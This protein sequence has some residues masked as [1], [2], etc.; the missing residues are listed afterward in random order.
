MILMYSSTYL[1]KIDD[2][3]HKDPIQKNNLF[4]DDKH[5]TRFKKF[6]VNGKLEISCIFKHK[7][8]VYNGNFLIPFEVYT[9]NLYI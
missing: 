5:H 1:T 4:E 9:Y 8:L 3:F 2:I 6:P 7:N